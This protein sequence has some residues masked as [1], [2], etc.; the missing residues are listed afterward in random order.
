[1]KLKHLVYWIRDLLIGGESGASHPGCLR[2]NPLRV[3]MSYPKWPASLGVFWLLSL[4]AVLDGFDG[5]AWALLGFATAGNYLWWSSIWG[6]FWRGDV[7]AGAIVSRDP[8]L[9]ASMTDLTTGQG[10]RPAIKVRR[11][12]ARRWPAEAIKIGKPVASVARYHGDFDNDSLSN[13]FP[14]A[15][16]CATANAAEEKRLLKEIERERWL[17][18]QAAINQLPTPIEPGLYRLST[19]DRLPAHG[20]EH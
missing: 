12:P 8:L 10:P 5:G 20:E 1:M 3:A 16:V 2:A 11:E 4:A 6:W 15:V 17:E 7:C 9:V 19:N 18:L 13:F 14:R